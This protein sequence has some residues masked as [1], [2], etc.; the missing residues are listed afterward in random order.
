MSIFK[1]RKTSGGEAAK[2]E[3]KTGDNG[4]LTAAER[5]RQ[6]LEN[7]EKMQ[8]AKK[9]KQEAARLAE[10]ERREQSRRERERRHWGSCSC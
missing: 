4:A 8:A 7:D 1:L 2:L 10:R 6:A 3:E 9:A 5:A